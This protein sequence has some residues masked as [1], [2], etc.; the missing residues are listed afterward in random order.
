MIY[1]VQEVERIVGIVP[2]G[3]SFVL[4]C[5]LAEVFKLLAFL[6]SIEELK[7]MSYDTEKAL[8]AF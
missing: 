2:A 3:S 7:V 1:K 6:K 5:L 8:K 4:S